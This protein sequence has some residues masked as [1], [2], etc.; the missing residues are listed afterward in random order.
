[1]GMGR[2]PARCY[3]QIQPRPFVKSRFVRAG[4]EP[5]IKIHDLGNKKAPVTDFPLIYHLISFNKEMI[6]S[7]SLEAAR[8]AANK[9]MVTRIG[10]D[11]Y[12]LR[13][14]IHPYNVLRI[15][16]ML[17]CAGADRL[18]TGMRGAYGK[19]YGLSAPVK[20]GQKILS[21]RARN[22]K[23]AESAMKIALTRARY[24]FPGTY[25]VV[26]AKEHG[27]TKYGKEEF[28]KLL[29]EG[30]VYPHGSG[31]VEIK[32]KGSIENMR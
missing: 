21:V 25:R 7:E 22:V 18:Q 5:K 27:F 12:H 14:N 13:I 16:K 32:G 28:K 17:S 31:M 4:L 19:P 3:R 30:K 1:M 29:E 24:K 6:S 8:I 26:K 9:Q 23:G 11:N 10:K 2:R 20:I 15:N